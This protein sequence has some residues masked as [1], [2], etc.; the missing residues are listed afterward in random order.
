ML[1]KQRN[2]ISCLIFIIITMLLIIPNL[3]YATINPSNYM[4]TGI[5]KEDVEKVEQ[6]VNPIIGI[7]KTI[8]IVV[9]VIT[10]AILGIKYMM[11]SASEKAEYKKTM[12]PYLIGA[13][14]VVAITQFLS[15]LI[16]IV[17]NIS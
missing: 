14:M 15:I 1:K 12:I 11:G 7:L 2:I 6:M 4:P 5:I 13:I 17:T 9:A 8:G 10:L 16:E 3:T